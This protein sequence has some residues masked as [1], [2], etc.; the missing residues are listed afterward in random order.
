MSD[1]KSRRQIPPVVL[2]KF[3]VE[4]SKQRA[5]I[6]KSNKHGKN[7]KVALASLRLKMR[8]VRRDWLRQQKTSAQNDENANEA[9]KSK[10]AEPR[11]ENPENPAKKSQKST[12]KRKV[13]EEENFASKFKIDTNWKMGTA[14]NKNWRKFLE[15][16]TKNRKQK[17]K[18]G[19]IVEVPENSRK[20]RKLD[21]SVHNEPKYSWEQQGP[22]S[23]QHFTSWHS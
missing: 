21:I 20:R 19:V 18:E 16:G 6:L 1:K 15:K 5:E 2:K 4:Y 12:K 14:A 23:Q 17:R 8:R 10:K 22:S 9:V 11:K 7:Q 13:V 3:D